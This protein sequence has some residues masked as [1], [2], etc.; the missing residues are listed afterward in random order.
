MF[1]SQRLTKSS[2]K[3]NH[4]RS[5]WNELVENLHRS[6]LVFYAYLYG[7]LSTLAGV[8]EWIVNRTTEIN[9][10]HL[11]NYWFFFAFS[12]SHFVYNAI[13]VFVAF[14]YPSECY[15]TNTNRNHKIFNDSKRN[16]CNVNITPRVTVFVINFLE[17][18]LWHYC[19]IGESRDYGVSDV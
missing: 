4:R 17:N 12:L 6:T 8:G 16:D 14:A 11:L 7:C 19:Q 15:S 10:K 18:F 5:M 13:K 3:I 9:L 2:V 1:V